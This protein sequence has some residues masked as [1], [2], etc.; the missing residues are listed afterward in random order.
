MRREKNGAEPSQVGEARPWSASGDEGKEGACG[1]RPFQ[2]AVEH[3]DSASERR[4]GTPSTVRYGDKFRG[5][6]GHEEIRVP[7]REREKTSRSRPLS[8]THCPFAGPLSFFLDFTAKVDR[9]M[10]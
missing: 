1:E 10:D 3:R 6:T 2:R 9:V 4:K 8:I 7:H 5:P